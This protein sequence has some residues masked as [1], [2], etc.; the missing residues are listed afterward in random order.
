MLGKGSKSTPAQNRNSQMAQ[1]FQ[2]LT[3]FTRD[4]S[5]A[6]NNDPKN[7]SEQDESSSDSDSDSSDSSQSCSDQE[8]QLPC[9]GQ[10]EQIING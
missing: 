5:E 7:I 8:F 4:V 2:E 3:Q 1:M 6:S 9:F 10:S